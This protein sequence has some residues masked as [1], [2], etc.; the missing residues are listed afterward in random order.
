MSARRSRSLPAIAAGAFLAAVTGCQSA[1][2]AGRSDIVRVSTFYSSQDVWLNFDQPP[3]LVPQGF[4]CSVFLTPAEGEQGAFGDGT[5]KFEIYRVDRDEQGA[6]ANTLVHTE[7]FEKERAY[8]YR[9]RI[10]KR[11]GWGYGFRIP[12][13]EADLRGQEIMVVVSFVR[14]DGRTI[15]G[16]PKYFK[17][18]MVARIP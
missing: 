3:T 12:W 8:G 11:Y 10:P 14:K 7:S 5:I 15:A 2:V 16:Q 1:R 9:G 6:G 4:K 17:V 13:G 18:P